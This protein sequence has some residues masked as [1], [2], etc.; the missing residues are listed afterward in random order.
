MVKEIENK[1][2]YQHEPTVEQMKQ[3]DQA[4]FLFKQLLTVVR[5]IADALHRLCKDHLVI[6]Q[7]RYKIAW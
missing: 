1:T 4:N 5:E 6:R 7:F 3:F 2:A